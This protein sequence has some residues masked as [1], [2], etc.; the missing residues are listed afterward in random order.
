M[1]KKLT[2]PEFIKRAQE[3]HK[4]KYDYS[5]VIYT[6]CQ[7]KIRIKCNRC[8]L[9]FEQFPTNHL[10]GQGCPKCGREQASKNIKLTSEEFLEKAHKVHGDRYDYS[11]TVYTHSQDKIKIIC[12]IHGEFFQKA[13]MHLHGNGCPEC[14]KKYQGPARKSTEEFVQEAQDIHNNKYDYSKTVYTGVK[15]K[16]CIICPKH[17]EFW[18]KPSSHLRGIGCPKCSSSK[19]ELFVEEILKELGLSYESQHYIGIS[20]N[21]V[22]VDFYLKFKDKEYII[23]YNGM[24]HYVP[25]KHFGGEFKFEQQTKRDKLLRDYCR[26]N[27]INFLEIRYDEP[28]NNI[29]KLIKT[30]LNYDQS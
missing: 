21:Y 28:Q 27:H 17:G 16:V 10:K 30:F 6:G 23:E 26:N 4:L 18:Q 29:I 5:K 15:N 13:A 20:G 9:V 7:K 24:Q 19:G 22:L 14:A 3:V 12:P 1:A 11:K 8:G 25:V 2:T